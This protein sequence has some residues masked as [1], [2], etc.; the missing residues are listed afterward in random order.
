M[1]AKRLSRNRR[2]VC[3][4]PQYVRSHGTPEHLRDLHRHNCI[5]LREDEGDYA[6]WRF[7]TD[8]DETAIRVDGSLSCNDGVVTTQWCIEGRGLMMRS[9]WHVA[10]LLRDGTLVHVFPEIPTP[11]ARINALYLASAHV[12]RR[13]RELVDHLAGG[14]ATRITG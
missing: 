10:P 13:I 12:A 2:I 5:V 1:T 11:S 9:L 7:G 3:A 14:L 4:S 8:N 6:L